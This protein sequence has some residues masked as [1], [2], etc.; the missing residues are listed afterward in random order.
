[1]SKQFTLNDAKTFIKHM[2]INIKKEKFTLT[3]IVK[4]MNVELE[5][6]S[7]DSTTNVT[8]NDLLITGKIALAHLKEFPDYYV[9]LDRLEEEAKKYWKTQNK[10]S[11]GNNIK[12]KKYVLKH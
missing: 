12:L 11:G 2:K 9:R 6:G 5:H 4:G 7:R 3:D 8:D 1:M 10:Q